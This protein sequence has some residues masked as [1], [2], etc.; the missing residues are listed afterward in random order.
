MAREMLNSLLQKQNQ[1]G[2]WKDVA[3]SYFSG[4]G[5]SKNRIRNMIIG[6]AL[7][8]AA[9]TRMENNVIKNLQESERQRVYEMAN[10]DAK[11]E[12]YNQ[13]VT[14]DEAYKADPF[15]F[16]QKSETE[17]NKKNPNYFES[18]GVT[19]DS[20]LKKKQEITEYEQALIKLH[21]EKIKTGN[22]TKRMT[23]AQFY[24]PFEDYYSAKAN[25][26]SAPKN[27]SLVHK[28]WDRLT[29]GKTVPL[30]PKEVQTKKDMATRSV[31]DYLLDPV[32]FTNEE[33]IE[34]Y[35]DPKTFTYTQDEAL[36]Y[37]SENVN[38]NDPARRSIISSLSDSKKTSW[39]KE[40]LKTH[41]VNSQ[42]DFNPI[43]EKN[44]TT[45]IAFNNEWTTKN[46]KDIPE[47]G[48]PEY[49]NYYLERENVVDE[50]NGTGD[51]KTRQLRRNIFELA[52]ISKIINESGKG[53]E[54]PMNPVK[55]KLE[56]D[57]KLA[58]VDSVKFEMYKMVSNRLGDP[59]K[60]PMIQAQIASNATAEEKQ[61]EGRTWK[62]STTGDY[63]TAAVN[64]LMS[65]FDVIFGD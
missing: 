64:E 20:K 37:L 27:L 3:A 51:A 21:E 56:N 32:E 34:M 18:Y 29:K 13:L 57:I 38:P 53:K 48:T 50:A 26:I 35:R 17:F 16:R 58:G 30:T 5:K 14:D 41:M 23:K 60:G 36:V 6:K 33:Q 2:S 22:I 52:D 28:G 59:L 62:Y 8:G 31:Y 4:T 39:S 43:I 54:H 1:S 15:Y 25:E 46:N 49:M 42:V 63:Y 55:K 12:K 24:K 7:F 10:L 11:Y 40:E 45:I 47:V 9:E 61:E 19:A 44:K 65:G